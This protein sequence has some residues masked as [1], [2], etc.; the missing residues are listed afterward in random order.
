MALV[1]HKDT[2]PELRVR[3]FFHAA[4]LRYRLHS[5]ALAGQ[6]DL[7]FSARRVA[8]FIHGCFWHRHPAPDCKLA[9]LPKSRLEFWQPK[10][11]GNA[12]RDIRNTLA[13][14]AAGWRVLIIWECETRDLAKLA[15]IADE[16]ARLDISPHQGKT[17]Q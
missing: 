3:R 14:E 9:R 8:V 5:K 15:A 1:R 10:L 11:D 17:S 6:P 7:I 2:K 16:I 13:L 12:A 4:G